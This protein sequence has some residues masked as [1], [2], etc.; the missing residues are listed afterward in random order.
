[1]VRNGSE[2]L[3]IKVH[4][5]DVASC[6]VAD[7]ELVRRK[8]DWVL[9]NQKQ[10]RRIL[11]GVEFGPEFSDG[12]F[13]VVFSGVLDNLQKVAVKVRHATGTRPDR[14]LFRELEH[15]RN[16]CRALKRYLG[17]MG[18]DDEMP[19]L[20]EMC[21]EFVP[22]LNLTFLCMPLLGQ[23]LFSTLSDRELY[24]M[25]DR[26][27]S[28]S[29]AELLV[30]LITALAILHATGR[31]HGDLKPENVCRDHRDAA[32]PWKLIDFASTWDTAGTPL[33]TAPEH[34]GIGCV[35]A[36]TQKRDM[37]ALGI[38]VWGLLCFEEPWHLARKSDKRFN[39]Y[40]RSPRDFVD[41]HVGR[42]D[43]D[44]DAFLLGVL[45]PEPSKRLCI[46]EVMG[47]AFARRAFG[48]YTSTSV[49][50]KNLA[51]KLWNP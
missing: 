13:A 32:F 5:K 37:W 39:K 14:S 51:E 38:M 15:Q 30:H 24:L 9:T 45:H 6:M 26:K 36:F 21:L 12:G 25:Q 2:P 40:V 41:Y 50:F 11:T 46:S 48:S 17:G 28:H 47:T 44:L 31:F 4:T 22:E 20:T 43:D 16:L 34:R 29:L 1:M 35:V 18:M 49:K 33:Y 27:M 7:K 8:M 19:V 3:R 23:D 42:G 10:G